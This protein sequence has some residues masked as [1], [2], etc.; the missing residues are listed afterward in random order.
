MG[1]PVIGT[2]EYVVKSPDLGPQQ[3]PEIL[4]FAPSL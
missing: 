2:L 1:R 3:V 4:E